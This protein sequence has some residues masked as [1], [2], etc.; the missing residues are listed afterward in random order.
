[1]TLVKAWKQLLLEDQTKK[2]PSASFTFPQAFELD[3]KLMYTGITRACNRLLFFETAQSEGFDAFRRCLTRQDL[4]EKMKMDNVLTE[5]TKLM[6]ADEWRVEGIE[7]ALQQSENSYDQ[8]D[9][10]ERAIFCFQK[11]GD[12]DLE[13]RANLQLEATKLE[14][15]ARQ[16]FL[17]DEKSPIAV[18][19]ATEAAKIYL[20]AGLTQDAS[21]LCND[22]C[23]SNGLTGLGGRI[24]KLITG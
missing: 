10:L 2:M 7:M 19:E 13:A 22:M 6:T 9:S 24:N 18:K 17:S 15:S 21:S 8:V 4:A 3:L 23:R 11:A 5:G 14:D 20:K 16:G 12:A 1:M